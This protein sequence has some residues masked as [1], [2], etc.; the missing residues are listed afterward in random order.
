[1]PPVSDQVRRNRVAGGKKAAASRKA[2]LAVRRFMAD[3]TPIAAAPARGTAR[4]DFSPGEI[5]ARIRA[6]EAGG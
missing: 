3:G 2:A 4:G 6:A 1:M 5:I